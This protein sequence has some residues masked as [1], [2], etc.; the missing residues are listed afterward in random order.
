MLSRVVHLKLSLYPANALEDRHDDEWLDLLRQFSAVRTLHVSGEFAGL[1]ALVLDDI[2]GDM[3]A[4]VL[5]FLDLIYLDGQ[6]V[7]SVG[8]FLAARQLSDHRVT[9]I[10]TEVGFYQRVKSYVSD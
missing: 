7:S 10:N 3:V 8:R 5:P 9:I 4:E 1:V 2:T 6:P